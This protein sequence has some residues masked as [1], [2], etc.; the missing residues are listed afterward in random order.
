ME[1]P[2][3]PFPAERRRK[4]IRENYPHYEEFQ[5]C[6]TKAYRLGLLTALSGMAA[7]Y[8][9]QELI[10]KYMFK[11]L[12]FNLRWRRTRILA[13]MFIGA[14]LSYALSTVRMME[15]QRIW[16]QI[17]KSHRESVLAHQNAPES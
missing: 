11:D 2:E 6:Q 12:N 3:S 17:E 15:C 7:V 13:P 4:Y 16:I 5:K 1:S 9:T 10:E 14:G 8:V